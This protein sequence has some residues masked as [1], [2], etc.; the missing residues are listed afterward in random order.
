MRGRR[1][2]LCEYGTA[3]VRA[4]IQ[5]PTVGTVTGVEHPVPHTNGTVDG[6]R[7]VGRR[8]VRLAG[9]LVVRGCL[10]TGS[11]V[12]AAAPLIILSPIGE[13]RLEV[14]V[15]RSQHRRDNRIRCCSVAVIWQGEGGLLAGLGTCLRICLLGLGSTT[16]RQRRD[17]AA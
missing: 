5:C 6:F 17:R 8:M 13:G 14:G 12:Q 10:L 4:G 2:A 11:G 3:I 1:P 15:I 7:G 9:G 16:S